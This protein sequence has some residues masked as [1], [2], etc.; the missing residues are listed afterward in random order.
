M[1]SFSSKT[2]C[3]EFLIEINKDCNGMWSS[4]SKAFCIELLI[5]SDKDC[6]EMWSSPSKKKIRILIKFWNASKSRGGMPQCLYIYIYILPWEYITI[7]AENIDF[8]AIENQ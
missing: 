1:W 2:F 3:I 6:N 4:S 8:I 7:H 5:E